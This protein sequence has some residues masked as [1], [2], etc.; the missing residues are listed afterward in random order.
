MYKR[1]LQDV[2]KH[3]GDANL[4]IAVMEFNTGCK[5]IPD[6]GPENMADFAW[7]DL[8]AGGLTD[9]GDALDELNNKMSTDVYKRQALD[10]TR[11]FRDFLLS[12]LAVQRLSDLI[13][14]EHQRCV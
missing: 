8:K 14:L 13:C 4:K 1:Q 12:G 6:N 11:K 2:A 9:I 5:W 3:N 7:E 10:S